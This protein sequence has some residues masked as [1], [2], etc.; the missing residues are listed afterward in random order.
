MRKIKIGVF[1]MDAVGDPFICRV[2]GD[3]TIEDLQSIQR[4]VVENRG[5]ELDREGHYEIEVGWFRGQYSRDG[6]C[7]T[8]PGWEWEVI[9]FDAIEEQGEAANDR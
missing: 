4:N 9:K 7:E 6:F 5:E 1:V 2:N 8:A 3:C